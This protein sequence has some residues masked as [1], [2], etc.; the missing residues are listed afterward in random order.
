M[1]YNKIV[2]VR[3]NKKIVIDMI[4]PQGPINKSEIAKKALLGN[5]HSILLTFDKKHREKVLTFRQ[6]AVIL[7]Q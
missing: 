7:Q 5:I 2:L 6:I 4:R 1:A 3:L